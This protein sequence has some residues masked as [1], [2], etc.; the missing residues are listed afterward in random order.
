MLKS[1]PLNQNLGSKVVAETTEATKW[2]FGQRSPRIAPGGNT[3]WTNAPISNRVGKPA[4]GPKSAA[5]GRLG[6]EI[7]QRASVL[8]EAATSY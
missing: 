5:P 7:T 2:P 4:L 3:E 6:M 1:P 8:A